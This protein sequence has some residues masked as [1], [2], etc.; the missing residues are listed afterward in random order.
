MGFADAAQQY[1]AE[2]TAAEPHGDADQRDAEQVEAAVGEAAGEHGALHGS[3]GDGSE[4]E[5]ERDEE[6]G[7]G[8]P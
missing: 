1:I 7:R 6:R 3:D 4:V 8:H 5:P 2:Q